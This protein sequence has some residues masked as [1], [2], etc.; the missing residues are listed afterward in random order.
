MLQRAGIACDC[1]A[2]L[3]VAVR[4][5]RAGS[6]R[7]TVSG[8]RAGAKPERPARRLSRVATC[9]VGPAGARSR[10]ARCGVRGR[11]AGHGPVRQRHRARAPDAR[12]RAGERSQKRASRA[13]AAI[14]APRP[15]RAAGAHGAPLAPERRGNANAARDAADRRIHCARPRVPADHGQSKRERALAH[16][17]RATTCPSPRAPGEAPAH[18]RVCRDGVELRRARAAAA[19]GRARRARARRS[20]GSGVRRRNRDQHLSVGHA[21]VR[22]RRTSPAA[23][24]ARSWT[25]PSTKRNE[26]AL[27]DADRR[28]DEF[29]AML[30]HELR[31]PLAPIRNSLHLLRM[32]N[33]H[34]PTA[35]HVCDDDGAPGRPHGPPGRRPPRRLAHH[36]RQDRA[37][38]GSRRGGGGRA[39]RRRDRPRADRGGRPS[40]G[41]STCPPSRWCSTP[42]P[43]PRPGHRE[44]AQQRGQVHRPGRRDPARGRAR[45]G[46][47][48]AISRARHR[49]RHRAREAA[50]ASSTSSCRSTRTAGARR[51]VSASASRS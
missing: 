2:R 35:R 36:A 39:P 7:G 1:F 14:P 8:R 26:S 47:A 19:A 40:A 20:G 38:Q 11:C 45:E 48:V 4:R 34:D 29:L 50:A 13:P 24:S 49:R 32:T 25:S 33:Q 21:A 44:P 12:R 10:P 9:V 30:A 43:A 51:A 27:R 18:F 3:G 41:P 17:A 46:A 37:A 42:I 23:P 16:V 28:K 31:N 6:G 22:R 15:S 5:A